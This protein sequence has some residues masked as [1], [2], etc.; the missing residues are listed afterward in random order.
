MPLYLDFKLHIFDMRKPPVADRNV[1][2]RDGLLTRL[3]VRKIVQGHHGN[4][5]ITDADLSPNNER[6]VINLSP[7]C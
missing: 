6:Y 1:P 7:L 3:P 5:T 4:W 2:R